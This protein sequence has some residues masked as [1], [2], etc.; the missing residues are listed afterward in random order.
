M[1][2][3]YIVTSH[4][5][6]HK[7]FRRHQHWPNVVSLGKVLGFEYGIGYDVQYEQCLTFLV[8]RIEA[9]ILA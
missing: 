9:V 6:P 3:I 4:Q 2:R 7:M 5:S 8:W 1:S